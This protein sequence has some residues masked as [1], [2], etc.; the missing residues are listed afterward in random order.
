MPVSA[1]YRRRH[2]VRAGVRAACKACTRDAARRARAENS[3]QGDPK[4]QQVRARTRAA[5]QRRELTA[6]PCE[7]C[8]NAEAFPHHR[9]YDGAEAYLEVNWLCRKHHGLEHGKRPWTKQ[10]ELFPELT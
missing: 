1:F 3:P 8:G 10:A 9:S 6:Q 5:I 7:I 4:K 2:Y